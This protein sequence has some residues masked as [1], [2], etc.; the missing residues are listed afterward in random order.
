MKTE[1]QIKQLR[2]SLALLVKQPC[3]CAGTAHELQCRIGGDM[4]FAVIKNLSWIL[5]ESDAEFDAHVER[6]LRNAAQV[7]RESN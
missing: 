1:A 4:M 7:R 2:D 3:G 6:L 5:G